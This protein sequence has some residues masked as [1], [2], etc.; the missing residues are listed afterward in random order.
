MKLLLLILINLSSS[1][2]YADLIL[3]GKMVAGESQNFVAPW[4]QTW[5]IQLKWMQ[6]EGN[7]VQKGDLVV[8]FD[9]A[10]LEAEIEQQESTL[11]AS[12]E[13][14]KEKILNLEQ[15]VIDAEHGLS[16]AKIKKKLAF[17]EANIPKKFRSEYE[18]ESAQF[19]KTKTTKEVTKASIKLTNKNQQLA[20]ERKK[21]ALEVF[22]IGEALKKKQNDLEKLHLYA[23]QSGPVLHAM[24]PWRGTKITVGQNV[25]TR[26]KVASIAG[27]DN[28]KVQAWINEV[29]WPQIKKQQAVMLMADSHPGVFFSGTIIKVGQQAEEK[30]EWGD[31]SYY[32]IDI[33]IDDK[34]EM[35]L[36][37]GMSI[38]V[39]VLK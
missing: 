37:P 25:Q 3:T 1:I 32:E 22:R 5:K 18:Y 36:I 33:S 24:H 26:W 30:Q 14:A 21:Q 10:N 16:Q 27:Y 29:D 11:R 19:D 38:Q 13:Q 6:Q 9:T 7:I 15:Q 20:A 28:M 4:T 31:A 2:A 39:R 35:R 8:V 23:N 17:L 12:K 34:P